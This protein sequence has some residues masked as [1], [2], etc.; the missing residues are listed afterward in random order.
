VG[1][2]KANAWGLIDVH[3]NAWEWCADWYAAD[4]Y[5]KGP[6]ED[7]PGPR[8]TGTCVMRGGSYYDARSCRTAHRNGLNPPTGRSTHVGFRV[9]LLR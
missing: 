4:Y 9:V 5:Q 1:E 8:A 6:K 7:P 3:G 2:K